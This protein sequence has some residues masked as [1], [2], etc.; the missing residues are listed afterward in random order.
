MT[1][2]EEKEKRWRK[3]YNTEH[4]GSFTRWSCYLAG[5]IARDKETKNLKE[6]VTS[7]LEQSRVRG[8][9]TV[10]EW[11]AIVSQATRLK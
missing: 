11:N 9:P 5:C 3:E 4:D 2:Q 7:I 10:T 6:I 1:V 8:Y